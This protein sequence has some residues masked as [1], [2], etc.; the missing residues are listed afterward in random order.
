M[1]YII[2]IVTLALLIPAVLLLV[3]TGLRRGRAKRLHSKT[4]QQPAA[5]G[6]VI[7]GVR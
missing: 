5:E 3:L 7:D 2:T 6:G 1:G 4:V